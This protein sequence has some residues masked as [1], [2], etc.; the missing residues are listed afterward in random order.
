MSQIPAAD[1]VP[2]QA[3]PPNADIYEEIVGDSTSNIARGFLDLIPPIP[4][5]S[6]IH[7]NGCGG[8]QVINV[9]MERKPPTDITFEATDIDPSQ[10]Q[11]CRDAATA[12]NWPARVTE[13]A[14]ESLQFADNTF[15]HSF[16]NLLLFATQNAGVDAAK[17][18][19][20]TLKPGGMAV[21]TWFNSIPHQELLKETHYELR[22][23]EAQLPHG[24]PE[25]WYDP[26]FL[27]GILLQGGFKPENLKMS[28]LE[29]PLTVPELKRWVEIMWSYLG[30]PIDGWAVAD[31]EKW[32]DAIA[33]LIRKMEQ[34]PSYIS[35]GD[36]GRMALR[37]NT[38]IATK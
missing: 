5:G 11:N 24:M 23:S 25:A 22:G 8:G 38:C 18:I 14:A 17:E 32:D 21:A 27:R 30:R 34:S 31:E 20:R 36:G 19:H 28:V 26:E 9:I 12:G 10:I 6:V 15:T 33:T 2:K 35:T 13:M 7:D 1:F 37:V 29:T 16:A 4:S 3:H